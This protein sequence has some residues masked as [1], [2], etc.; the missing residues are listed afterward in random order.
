M[1]N[2]DMLREIML[3]LN[4]IINIVGNISPKVNYFHLCLNNNIAV[5]DILINCHKMQH[6]VL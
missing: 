2:K 4:S 5:N 3:A 6:I 1:T